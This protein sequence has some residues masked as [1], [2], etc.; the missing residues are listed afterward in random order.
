[1][2][3]R[4]GCAGHQGERNSTPS[5][6]A[7]RRHRDAAVTSEESLEHAAEQR[8]CAD[9]SHERAPT[10]ENP[11]GPGSARARP[12]LRAGRATNGNSFVCIDATV[13][14][15]VCRSRRAHRSRERA[16]RCRRA[17]NLKLVGTTAV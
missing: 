6:V 14:L 8:R 2:A 4:A 11:A 7:D 17:L 15:T 1:V 13:T 3:K 10:S 5:L 9:R 12:G 16:R